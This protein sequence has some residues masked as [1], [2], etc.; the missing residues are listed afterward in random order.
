LTQSFRPHYDPEVDST[1][2]GNEYQEYFLGSKGGPCVGLAN[3][4]PS[5]ADCS[6]IWKLHTLGIM[7]D[8]PD[9]YRVCF[10]IASTE[11]RNVNF[12]V[13]KTSKTGQTIQYTKIR[14]LPASPLQRRNC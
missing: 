12:S 4:P 5:C 9:L 7:G 3:L 1:S 14:S 8:C 11:R 13:R 10:T 6:E 2:D